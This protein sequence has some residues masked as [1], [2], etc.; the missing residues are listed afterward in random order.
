MVFYVDGDVG[1]IGSFYVEGIWVCYFELEFFYFGEIEIDDFGVCG[2]VEVQDFEVFGCQ[3]GFLYVE[4]VY[5]GQGYEC[6]Y[7]C[8]NVGERF[9]GYFNV[10]EGEIFYIGYLLEIFCVEEYVVQ[11]QG[12]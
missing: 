8:V 7:V 1:E 11:F 2:E 12:L 9:F 5:E 10:L 6:G 3:V 4:D